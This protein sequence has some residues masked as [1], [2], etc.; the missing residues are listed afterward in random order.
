[1]LFRSFL[2]G[3]SPDSLDAMAQAGQAAG[4]PAEKLVEAG[5]C[6]QRDDGS[7]WDFFKGRVMFPIRDVTGRVIGFG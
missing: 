2:I 4:Y 7:L 5:L 1:M 6:K 3:Y